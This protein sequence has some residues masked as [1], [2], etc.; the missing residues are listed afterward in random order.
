M[1]TALGDSQQYEI[2]SF[3]EVDEAKKELAILASRIEAT[4]RKLVLE[5][6]LRDAAQS[7]NRLSTNKGRDVSGEGSPNSPKRHRRSFIGSRSSGGSDLFIKTDSEMAAITRQCEELAQELWKLEQR[8]QKLHRVLLEHTAGILQMTHKGYLSKVAP[9]GTPETMHSY[10]RGG[11]RLN[12]GADDFDE[13]SWYRSHD[14]LDEFVRGFENERH[15]G[16]S[17]LISQESSTRAP[18]IEEFARQTEAIESTEKK[19]KNLNTRLREMLGHANIHQLVTTPPSQSN[20]HSQETNLEE[21]LSLLEIGL[22]ELSQSHSNSLNRVET[23]SHLTEQRIQ[24]INTRLHANMNRS[25]ELQGSEYTTPPQASG[26]STQDQINYLEGGLDVM[27][28]RIQHLRDALHTSSS[29]STSHEQK[30]EQ[31]E[32]VITG[33]WSIMFVDEAIERQQSGHDRSVGLRDVNDG[34]EHEFSLQKFSARFQALY[35]RATALEEQ[36]E[37]LTRQLQQQREDGNRSI[38]EKDSHL[39]N[40]GSEHENMK[41]ILETT[42]RQAKATEVQLALALEQ[43]DAAK[44]HAILREEQRGLDD[45]NALKAEKAARKEAEEQFLQELQAKE[46]GISE[47]AARLTEARDEGGVVMTELQAKLHESEK[48]VQELSAQ[49]NEIIEARAQFEGTEAQLKRTAEEKTKEAERI[50]QE[51]KGLEGEVVRLHTELTVAR[52][53]LDGAYGTRAQRAAEV[54]ANPAVQKELDDLSDRNKSL[55]EE[56]TALKAHGSSASSGNSELT[57]RIELLQRE[58][59]ETIGEYEIMT[60]SSIEFEKERE[61]LEAEIDGLRDR[62]ENLDSQLSDEKVRWLGMSSQGSGGRD[63]LVPSNTSTMVLKSEFR[64]MMRGTRAE[65]MKAL[66]VR[67]YCGMEHYD[68]NA[69]SRPNKKSVGNLRPS[70]EL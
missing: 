32:T 1:E 49:L 45:G 26:H 56:I 40:L 23:Q 34:H 28:Q 64:K 70:Y 53:E 19:L 35:R 54:A 65:Y 31:L 8:A 63:S 44:K 30:A 47:L 4:K 57:E 20:E 52:A 38:S 41:R 43:L 2:L 62:C 69:P 36:K 13:R 3:E 5:S 10:G 22:E 55:L 7:L 12:D 9:P 11:S 67:F 18:Q 50:H 37:I 24:G 14:S 21:Q 68:T 66:R 16:D 25:G 46:E 51:M 27:E 17:R 60:K 6:K 29:R 33:L 58:L 48:R 59:A 15:Q 61:Q 42:G 39:A